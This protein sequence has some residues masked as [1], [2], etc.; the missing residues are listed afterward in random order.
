MNNNI[1]F[2]NLEILKTFDE[3]SLP[4]LDI[5]T[6]GALELFQQNKP[7]KIDLSKHKKPLVI[8]SGNAITTAKILFENKNA[9]FANE[10]DYKNKLDL[11]ID[12]VYIFSASGGKH[13]PILAKAA[14]QKDLPTYLIT[15]TKNSQGEEIIGSENT[16]VTKKNREPYTYNTSTYLGWVLAKTGENP[17]EIIDYIENTIKP[18]IPNNFNKYNGFLFVT[19]DFCLNLNRLFEV[20]FIELFGRKIA[21]D[22]QSKEELKHA[23]TVV[24]SE[25]ELCINFSGDKNIDY[26]GDRLDINLSQG[27]GQASVMAIVYY[28]IGQIQKQN[29]PYFKEHI[30]EYIQRNAKG[31]FGKSIS[32]IVE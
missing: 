32:T 30:K 18:L 4:D 14:K 17:T 3:N 27:L 16:T 11:D 19:P 7:E 2:K 25:T 8:G 6:L 21:K 9:I 22:V 26:V 15:C 20:K 5:V 28:I 29:H 31:D 12:S 10:S 24:P 1:N 13:A 23:I